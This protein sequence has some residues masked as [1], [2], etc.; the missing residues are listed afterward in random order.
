MMGHAKRD[1]AYSVH[2]ALFRAA[3][4][5]LPEQRPPGIFAVTRQKYGHAGG[6]PGKKREH[7][8][9]KDSIPILDSLTSAQKKAASTLF[10]EVVVI[11]PVLEINS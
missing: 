10:A 4:W 2:L 1:I 8:I 7:F 11:I 6:L 5:H 3:T 9:D